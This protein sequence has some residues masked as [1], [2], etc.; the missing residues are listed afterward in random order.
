MPLVSP[1][2]KCY[3]TP[4][5]SKLLEFFRFFSHLFMRNLVRLSH[6]WEWLSSLGGLK[7]FMSAL[8]HNP[9][10]VSPPSL[11][12]TASSGTFVWRRW[13]WHLFCAW[14]FFALCSFLLLHSPLFVVGLVVCSRPIT[15]YLEQPVAFSP[16]KNSL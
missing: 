13:R 10:P 16:H 3:M 12:L 9:Q 14:H 7:A 1:A 11:G 5:F 6:Q 8:F 2:G 4:F 15:I